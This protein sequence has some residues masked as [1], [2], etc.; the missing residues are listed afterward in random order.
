MSADSTSAPIGHYNQNVNRFSTAV[1]VAQCV[2]PLALLISPQAFLVAITYKVV[3][4]I[5]FCVYRI[6]QESRMA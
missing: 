6:S 2:V 5:V 1:L 3:V 4:T